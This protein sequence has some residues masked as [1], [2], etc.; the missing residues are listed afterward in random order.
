MTETA[1]K[2][3]GFLVVSLSL[4]GFLLHVAPQVPPA[5]SVEVTL[6]PFIPVTYQH[7]PSVPPLQS[8]TEVES[9]PLKMRETFRYHRRVT[10]PQST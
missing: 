2:E 6:P 8:V 5:G 1:K 3:E 7:S 4:L 9:F 10:E